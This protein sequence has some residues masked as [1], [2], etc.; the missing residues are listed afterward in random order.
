MTARDRLVDQQCLRHELAEQA[1]RAPSVRVPEG[2]RIAGTR[3]REGRQQSVSVLH[4]PT[5]CRAMCTERS[6]QKTADKAVATIQ[7]FFPLFRV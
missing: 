5:G 4:V 3:T 1:I 7:S 6:Y 2:Y